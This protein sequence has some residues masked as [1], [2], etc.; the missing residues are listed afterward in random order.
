MIKQSTT[1]TIRTVRRRSLRVTRGVLLI[2]CPV[3]NREVEMLTRSQA[4]EILQVHDA[5]VDRLITARK[6]HAI[7]TVSGNFCICK[8][9]LFA[10]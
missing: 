1:V 10:G 9:S 3:C 5:A 7:L 2:S 8:P 6:L 4:A